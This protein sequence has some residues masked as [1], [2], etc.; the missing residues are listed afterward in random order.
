MKKTHRGGDW[1]GGEGQQGRS[2]FCW[3]DSPW[4]EAE[5]YSR[6]LLPR[7]RERRVETGERPPASERSGIR[8]LQK[9]E[10]RPRADLRAQTPRRASAGRG[11]RGLPGR[12]APA[13]S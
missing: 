10:I 3:E 2:P 8:R 12:C 7:G 9:F 4:P 13:L 5:L 1:P 11:E 6:R